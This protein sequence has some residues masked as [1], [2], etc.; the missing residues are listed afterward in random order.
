MN[1]TVLFSALLAVMVLMNAGPAAGQAKRFQGEWKSTKG[2]AAQ[3]L[4][5]LDIAVHGA[6]VEVSA[7][8]PCEGTFVTRYGPPSPRS[9]A[10]SLGALSADDN[11]QQSSC[12]PVHLRPIRAQI[13]ASNDNDDLAGKASTLLV[14][15]PDRLVIL[16]LQGDNL[17]ATVFSQ[18]RVEHD[19]FKH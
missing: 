9:L 12:I 4:R 7:W 14:E 10:T 17:S 2:S 6:N 1:K 19:L 16:E 15:F 18:G 8:S 5:K 13:Y 3:H 11:V